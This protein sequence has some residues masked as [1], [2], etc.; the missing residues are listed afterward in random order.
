MCSFLFNKPKKEEINVEDIKDTRSF[1]FSYD[2]GNYMNGNVIFELNIDENNKYIISYKANQIPNEE[3]L[4]K[5]ISKEDVLKIEEILKKYEV[6]KWHDFKESDLNVLD[7][8]G[9]QLNYNTLNYKRISA[10]GYEMFPENYTN[11]K[12]E[13][14]EFYLQQFSEEIEKQKVTK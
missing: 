12:K 8:R 1:H 11:F 9:F 5:E 13:I 2:V 4:I 3:K 6:N 7:G 10:F 14:E